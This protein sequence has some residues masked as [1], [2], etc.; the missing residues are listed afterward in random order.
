MKK[1]T[2]KLTVIIADPSPFAIIGEPVQHRS[3]SIEFTPCQLAALELYE[4][5]IEA[6]QP[7]M[8]FYSS[9]FIEKGESE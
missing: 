9:C 3:V 8:E 2:I 5:G 6:G 7:V 4:T 1:T